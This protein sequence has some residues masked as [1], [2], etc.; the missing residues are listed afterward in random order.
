[1]WMVENDAQMEQKHAQPKEV[2]SEK[3]S[4]SE[5]HSLS[6]AVSRMDTPPTLTNTEPPI[7]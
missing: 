6:Q 1:M 7:G 2:N 4:V 3:Q 5:R